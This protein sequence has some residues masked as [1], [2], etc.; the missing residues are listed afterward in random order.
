V[1]GAWLRY[2]A[3]NGQQ[4]ARWTTNEVAAVY[5]L[6]W[7]S[8]AGSD[9]D[10]MPHRLRVRK[11]RVIN[12]ALGQELKLPIAAKDAL[13]YG[14]SEI[15]YRGVSY[16]VEEFFEERRPQLPALPSD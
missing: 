5:G 3:D 1:S 10:A 9:L 14:L 8:R 13:V 11:V 12:A 2:A 15:V 6:A 16:T 7:D 4:F